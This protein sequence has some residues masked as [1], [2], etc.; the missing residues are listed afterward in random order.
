MCTLALVLSSIT[1]PR[2]GV[3]RDY[4][5]SAPKHWF[6][7]LRWLWHSLATGLPLLLAMLALAG[8]TYT[9]GTL[10]TGRMIQTI[11]LVLGLVVVNQIVLRWLTL[12]RR[13][14]SFQ[15]ALEQRAAREAER[16]KEKAGGPTGADDEADLLPAVEPTPVDLELVDQQ[17]RRLL[18]S[19][20]FLVAI[21]GCWGI[22]SEMLPVLSILNEISLWTETIT[23]DGVATQSPVTIADLFVALGAGIITLIASR[24]LP[25]LLEIAVLQRLDLQPGSRYTIVTLVRYV[26]VTVGLIT[27]LGIIVWNWSRI[28]WLVAALS[29][30]LGFGLQEIVANFVSGLI[31]LFERPVR[32]GDTVTVGNLTGS[33]SKVRIRATTITDWDRK[34]IIVPNKAF[35]T[36]QVVNWTLSDPITRLTIE[37]G[38]SYSTDMHLAQEVIESA[39]MKQP[40]IL[41]EPKPAVYFVGFGESSLNFRI[42]VYARQLA[43]RFPIYHAVHQDLLQALRDNGIE[44]P[45]PQRDLH[46]KS[47]TPD[48]SPRRREDESDK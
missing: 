28:Q 12:T 31:I 23:V 40:L 42:Y 34:E 33:V 13:K 27:V 8:F 17:T 39:L 32:V 2:S 18:R 7:K 47:V 20:L 5:E 14:I 3:L 6:A 29:V 37:V 46:V 9:A 36:D 43:D 19:G 21:L 16:E 44:I 48:L 1:S 22:W 24:N 4:Y 26:V 11:W 30:G 38:V 10:L 35:I 41:D 15:R 45:F 25:G